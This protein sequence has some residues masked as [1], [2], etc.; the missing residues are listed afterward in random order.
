MLVHNSVVVV[1]TVPAGAC[2]EG[3]RTSKEAIGKQS[4][5]L[6]LRLLSR[7]LSIYW[8][9]LDEPGINWKSSSAKNAKGSRHMNR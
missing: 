3:S 2:H 1:Q 5:Q 9:V 6:V 7:L 4:E 8:R